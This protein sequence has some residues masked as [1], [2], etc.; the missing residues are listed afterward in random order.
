MEDDKKNLVTVQKHDP[1]IPERIHTTIDKENK[2]MEHINEV[3]TDPEGERS[4]STKRD[5]PKNES[6]VPAIPSEPADRYLEAGREVGD[7]PFLKFKKGKYT[8]GGDEEEIPLGTRLVAVMTQCCRGLLKWEDGKLVD[9]CMANI[10]DGEL[11][12]SR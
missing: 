7:T 1:E 9:R 8:V 4:M 3:T 12:P 10:G 2:H 5:D 11:A 6:Q